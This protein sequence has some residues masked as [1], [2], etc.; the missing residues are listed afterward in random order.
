[1]SSNLIDGTQ[2]ASGTLWL[3]TQ[4]LMYPQKVTAY[5]SLWKPPSLNAMY[6]PKL[7]QAI[8][9]ANP[10]HVSS[11]VW[12]AL[13]HGGRSRLHGFWRGAKSVAL[14]PCAASKVFHSFFIPTAMGSIVRG[15]KAHRCILRVHP[16][17][18]GIVQHTVFYATCG[19]LALHI[20]TLRSRKTGL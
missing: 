7:A 20:M 18:N 13:H 11:V 12:S 15:R 1:M 2:A 5:R 8:L 6:F 16:I 9:Q 10:T 3:R 17:Q 4:I 14:R 19:A